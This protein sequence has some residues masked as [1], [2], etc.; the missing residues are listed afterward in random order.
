[1]LKLNK[2]HIVK[3][4]N[5]VW[6]DK[7][8]LLHL[9]LHCFLVLAAFFLAGVLW[10][11]WRKVIKTSWDTCQFRCS[12]QSYMM[13]LVYVIICASVTSSFQQCSMDYIVRIRGYGWCFDS[14]Y[15]VY[16]MACNCSINIETSRLTVSM[17]SYLAD[18]YDSI[19]FI[20]ISWHNF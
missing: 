12:P 2:F 13:T 16:I 17:N 7:E 8:V 14:H 3:S 15:D 6:I 19:D 20:E 4:R 10:L 1:M 11:D 5:A 9:S 18:T